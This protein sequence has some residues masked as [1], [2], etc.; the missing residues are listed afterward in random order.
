MSAPVNT[1]PIWVSLMPKVSMMGVV[2]GPISNLSDW[3]SN[4]KKKKMA[5]TNHR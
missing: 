5:I 2:S 1:A 3:C 4:I